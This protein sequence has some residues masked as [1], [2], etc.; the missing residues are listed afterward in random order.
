MT[1]V[2]KPPKWVRVGP[3]RYRVRM[4]DALLPDA[5]C[6]GLCS[7]DRLTIAVYADQARSQLADT[8]LH[9]LTHA[10]L[11][12]AG[13]EKDAEE[14]IALTLGPGLLALIRD[15]PDLIEWVRS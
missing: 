4:V 8:L 9:E 14:A 12:T 6:D 1:R 5:G 10:M 2:R 3:H 7:R 13:L 15:N 11:A